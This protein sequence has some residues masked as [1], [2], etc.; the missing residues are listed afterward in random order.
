MHH[1]LSMIT[2]G[3]LIEQV[4]V[5][6][7]VP[8]GTVSLAFRGLREA[9]LVTTGARG[10]NAPPMT[11]LDAAR[12]LIVLAVTD[13]PSRAAEVVADFGGLI[14]DQGRRAEDA[15]AQAIV[16][17]AADPLAFGGVNLIVHL[18]KLAIEIKTGSG[19]AAAMFIH[20]H[21]WTEPH[22]SDDDLDLDAITAEMDADA[23]FRPTL[24][25]YAN[26]IK[27]TRALPPRLLTAVASRFAPPTSAADA[28][29]A[30]P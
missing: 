4:A 20:P 3:V 29:D 26:N 19:E 15:L 25:R 28:Q 22:G 1:A 2:S 7:G 17:M 11:P 5:S 21:Y 8:V 13:R 10:V 16:S 24:D 12:L 6:T 18:Q 30:R 9:G 14:D 23:A 27:T